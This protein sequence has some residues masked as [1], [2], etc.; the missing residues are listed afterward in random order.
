MPAHA[1]RRRALSLAVLAALASFTA[2]AQS[3]PTDPADADKRVLDTVQVVGSSET[4]TK[5]DTPIAEIPQ[6]VSVIGSEEMRN[7]AVHGVEEAVWFTAGAQGGGY[8]PD[9]RSDWLLVRGFTPAR[10]LDGLSLADGSGTG[11]T[12]IEPYGLERVEVLKGPASVGYG[13]MPPGG[14]LNYISKRPTEV[15]LREVEVQAGTFGLAQAAVDFGGALNDSGTWL[16]RLTALARNSD[17]VVDYVHD[18]RYYVAP[19]LTWKPDEANTLTLLARYQRNDT[20]AGGGFLPSQGTLDPNP[21]GKI[22]I[23]RYTGEPGFNTYDKTM[24]SAGWEF[25]HDFGGGTVFGQSARYGTTD[26]DPATT[27]GA[28]GLLG[29]LR[30][31]FRYLWATEEESKNFGIDNHLQFRF[32]TGGAEHTV[33]M[34]MDYRN[35]RNNYASAFS[36]TAPTL[37][38]FDPVYGATIVRPDYTSR[39]VQ[40]QSQVGFYLQDQVKVD[41]WVVTVGGRQDFVGTTTEDQIVGGGGRRQSDDKFS[42]RVGVN[43]MFDNGLAPYAGWSQSFQP[44]VGTDFSGRAFVP[45]TGE[46]VELGLKYQPRGNRILATLAAYRLLQQNTLTVDPNH[47]LY[48]I[49]QGE[50]EV[51]GVELEGRWYAT[52]GLSLFGA[53]TYTDSEVTQSTDLLSLGKQIPLQP[54]HV[55]SLGF[56]YT[57]TAGALSGFGFGASSRYTGEHFGDAYNAWETP[58]Y[59]LFDAAVH[60]D[61]GP[62]RLQLNANNLADKEYISACNSAAW[63]YYGYPRTVTATARYQW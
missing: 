55:A 36:F 19:A 4:A 62:W 31:L 53:Y 16:Y 42:G 63:C 7:R 48:S 34:G 33:L 52:D 21:N 41:R 27:V 5:T 46:Q 51:R 23:N 17:D 12:R 18:D 58:S 11:I 20:V 26:I 38:I 37:D 25:T 35:A 8:G 10:Y 60:Y 30:T 57:F 45:T 13:A 9:P 28:F 32:A 3:G 6:S 44:T 15:D 50:T 40:H 24:Q 14:L 47:T 1:A 56:D 39:V 59:T 49:Q 54:E 29:D 43:Y 2:A 22:P 61:V